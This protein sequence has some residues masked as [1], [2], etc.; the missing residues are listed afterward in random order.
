MAPPK[1]STI[2][3]DSLVR[4]T[5]QKE[6]IGFF[7][8]GRQRMHDDFYIKCYSNNI[9][10]KNRDYWKITLMFTSGEM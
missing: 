6:I 5:V 2:S 10:D 7:S 3:N 8:K 1:I 9:R 4:N